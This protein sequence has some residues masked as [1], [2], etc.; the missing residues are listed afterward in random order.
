MKSLLSSRFLFVAVVLIVCTV[1]LFQN[2]GIAGS[3]VSAEN[4]DT[5]STLAASAP[6]RVD[7]ALAG[8]LIGGALFTLL[9]PRR[10]AAVRVTTK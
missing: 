1:L 10:K 5:D 6:P 7:W 2:M 3:Q 9:R 8:L 4:A